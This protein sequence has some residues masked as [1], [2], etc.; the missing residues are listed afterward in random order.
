MV[1]NSGNLAK[2][3]SKKGF[4]LFEVVLCL[5]IIALVFGGIIQGYTSA[6]YRAEWTGYSL[7]AQALA[8][9]SIEQAR[10]ATWD[11]AIGTDDIPG[12]LKALGNYNSNLVSGTV[13]SGVVMMKGATNRVLDLPTTPGQSTNYATI[14][15]TATRY[16]PLPGLGGNNM[17]VIQV[18]ALWAFQ[19]KHRTNYYT[20]TLVTY[21]APDNQS[22][23]SL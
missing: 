21:M 1:I 23:S 2:L 4:T 5:V 16:Q 6:T 20:N 17:Y 22:P 13:A 9:Q 3:R 8:L 19:W 7:A 14:T 15:V 10:S 12:M 11:T 18:D